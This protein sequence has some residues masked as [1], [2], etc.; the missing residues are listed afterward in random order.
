[1]MMSSNRER[2]LSDTFEIETD[3]GDYKPVVTDN[4][5]IVTSRLTNESA[6]ESY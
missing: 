4:F 5:G 6:F 1:M 3:E 2:G